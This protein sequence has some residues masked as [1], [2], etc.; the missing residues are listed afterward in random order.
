MQK[1]LP[2]ITGHVIAD[3]LFDQIAYIFKIL[4]NDR[5]Y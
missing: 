5:I 4:E 2:R 1:K 3:I